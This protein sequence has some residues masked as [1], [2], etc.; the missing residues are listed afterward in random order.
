MT[1]QR[2]LR[3]KWTL[4]KKKNVH[5]G[6]ALTVDTDQP[7]LSIKH[8]PCAVELAKDPSFEQSFWHREQRL[9]LDYLSLVCVMA[10][11]SSRPMKV[12]LSQS[13]DQLILFLGR[14]RL[15]PNVASYYQVHTLLLVTDNCPF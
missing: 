10:L 14:L 15:A 11:E 3:P 6:C 12:M 2:Q 7:Q 8:V 1:R 4:C 13:V 5:I 9:Q